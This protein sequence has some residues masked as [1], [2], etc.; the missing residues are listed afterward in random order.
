M[1]ARIDALLADA[2][3]AVATLKATTAANKEAAL[4]AFV[5]SALATHA[6]VKAS[7]KGGATRLAALNKEAGVGYGSPAAVGFHA[8]TGQVLSLPEGE[9]DDDNPLSSPT[10][11]QALVKK[12]GQEKSKEILRT[13]RTQV[14]V[15]KA[16]KAAVQPDSPE[17]LLKAARKKVE[18][19]TVALAALKIALSDEARQEADEIVALIDALIDPDQAV[20]IPSVPDDAS[21]LLE[22]VAAA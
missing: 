1:S 14:A 6:V 2:H 22:E 10:A 13:A 5:A 12:V 20:I 19:A 21:S 8:V 4:A 11:I 3:R 7:P 17:A 18:D 15:A 16:L 9:V